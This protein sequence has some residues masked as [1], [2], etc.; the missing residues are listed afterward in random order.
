MRHRRPLFALLPHHNT[1]EAQVLS[2][3]RDYFRRLRLSASDILRL[4]EHIVA[5]LRARKPLTL[6]KQEIEIKLRFLPYQR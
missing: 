1:T 6:I 3:Y 2:Q 4:E 5:G